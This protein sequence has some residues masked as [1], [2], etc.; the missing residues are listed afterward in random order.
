MHM[1]IHVQR[2]DIQDSGFRIQE[3]WKYMYGSVEANLKQRQGI[4]ET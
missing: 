1:Y 3:V 2:L 4:L